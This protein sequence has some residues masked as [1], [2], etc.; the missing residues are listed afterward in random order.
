MGVIDFKP[1]RLSYDDLR[2]I[3]NKFL[4]EHHRSDE[5][6]IPIEEIV[7]F[8]LGID[9]VP[10]P[11]LIKTWDVDGFISGDLSEITVDQ[12]ILENR[13]ERYRYTL[14][15]EVGHLVLHKDIIKKNWPKDIKKYKDMI[16]SIPEEDYRWLEWQ[17]Y[18][19]AGLVLVPKKHL[20]REVCPLIK[21]VQVYTTLSDELLDPVWDRIAEKLGPKFCVSKDV[22]IK[23]LKYDGYR[24]TE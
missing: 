7:E 14:A 20:E 19:F 13:E 16:N 18:S 21:H 11:N 23:R 1:K 6:P 3:A 17:A 9:I 22:I 2:Q 4:K 5:Y 15:H 24:G 12:F 10:I 8:K